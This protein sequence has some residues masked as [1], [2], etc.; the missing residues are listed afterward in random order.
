MMS[1]AQAEVREAF[2]RDMK[3]HEEGL[4][5]LSYLQW[6]IK[7]TLRL[8]IPGS[9]LFPKECRETCKVLGYDVP[10]GTML[11]VNAWAISRDPEYWDEPETFKPERFE[12]DTRDYRGNDFEFTPF[13]AG[14]RICPG[15]SFGV[16]VVEL[17][18]ANLL[19]YFDWSLPEGMSPNELDMTE[20]MGITLR[21][22][23]DLWLKATMHSK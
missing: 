16:A 10:Q 6:V 8:H 14:R 5:K 9:F 22:K 2:E 12:T 20:S 13:G 1:R 19:F 4:C 3:V 21:R 17:A 23:R 7:E 18:L 11:L 15:I